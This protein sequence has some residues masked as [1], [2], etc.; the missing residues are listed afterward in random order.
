MS[1]PF[2]W[3]HLAWSCTRNT[4][5]S[6]GCDLLARWFS[7]NPAD[8]G[9]G[10]SYGQESQNCSGQLVDPM[11]WVG[12]TWWGKMGIASWCSI[13]MVLPVP[14]QSPA[15]RWASSEEGLLKCI[16]LWGLEWSGPFSRVKGWYWPVAGQ[17][18]VP[19]E[20]E[21]SLCP[22]H[23]SVVRASVH[24]FLESD[25]EKI[26]KDKISSSVTPIREN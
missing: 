26:K 11:Q 6:S 20:N 22:F 23:G 1:A 15:L 5:R 8:H 24:T 16:V 25:P 14:S 12:S 3:P 7:Q 19:R 4:L 10:R 13:Q 2:R 9:L 18:S 17:P 21:T